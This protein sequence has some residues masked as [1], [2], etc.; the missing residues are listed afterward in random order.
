MLHSNLIPPSPAPLLSLEAVFVLGGG[1]G[2]KPALLPL[3]FSRP[4][5]DSFALVAGAVHHIIIISPICT[6]YGAK[7]ASH[8]AI[9]LRGIGLVLAV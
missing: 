8:L 5:V 7:D 1:A 9:L 4:G 3:A 6:G 2:A